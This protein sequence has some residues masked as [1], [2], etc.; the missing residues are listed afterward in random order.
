MAGIEA[1][2]R[3]TGPGGPPPAAGDGGRRGRVRLR[4]TPPSRRTSLIALVLLTVLAGGGTWAVYGSGWFRANRVTVRGEQVLTADQ[5][6]RAAAVPLGGP[7]VSVDTGAVRRRLLAALPRIDRVDVSRSWPHTVTV[8]VTERVPSAVLENGPKFTEVD[9]DGVRF[10]TVDRAPAG[11][12]L[13]ELAPD[14]KGAA[15]SLRVFGTSRLLQSAI[16]V[17]GDLPDSLKGHATAIRV[18]SWDGITVELA[19]GRDVMWGSAEQG[20]FKAS[21]LA[22]LMKAEPRARHFDVSAPTAPAASGS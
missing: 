16:A 4:I 18:R 1:R 11:V 19:G 20:A 10:A 7:L 21:V 13:V 14:A 6:E 9:R 12:P 17:S 8:T 22:A 5:I 3:G 15:A 2:P